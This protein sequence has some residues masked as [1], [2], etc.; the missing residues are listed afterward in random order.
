MKNKNALAVVI[1][2]I[3]LFAIRT[4][5]IEGVPL[6]VIA[7]IM[8]LCMI[9]SFIIVKNYKGSKKEMPY[10]YGLI[11]MTTL[12]LGSIIIFVQIDNQY[13]EVASTHKPLFLSIII[14]FFVGLNFVAL[15][16][17]SYKS[18]FKPKK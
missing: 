9:I 17:A 6:P 15:A 10:L 12:L 11:I 4:I 7:G 8:V 14:I 5:G 13:P 16:Y 2:S 18:N 3:A 1:I